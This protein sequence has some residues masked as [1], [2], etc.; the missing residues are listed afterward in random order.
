M[1]PHQYLSCIPLV[2]MVHAFTLPL[3]T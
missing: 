2:F 1:S 3:F